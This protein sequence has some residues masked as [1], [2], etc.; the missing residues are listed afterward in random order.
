MKEIVLSIGSYDGLHLGHQSIIKR[1]K[2]ISLDKKISSAIFFFEIP[3]KLYLKGEFKNILITTPDERRNIIKGLGIDEIIPID[4]NE[5]IHLMEPDSFFKKFVF[6]KYKVSD[7]VVGKDFA[8]GYKR[9]GD[10]L[11]L[12]SYSNNIGFKLHIVDFVKYKD[13]KISSSLIRELIKK[14]EMEDVNNML[15]RKYSFHGIVKKGAGIGRKLGY[16]TANIDVDEKKLLPHGVFVVEVI[17][18]GVKY[19][20]VGSIGRRPTLKTLNEELIA[21]VHIL[22]FNQEIYGKKIEIFIIHK[23]RDEKKFNSVD[24]LISQIKEDVFYTQRYFTSCKKI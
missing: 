1:I 17:I 15:G 2:Q 4:F 8:L 14:G 21:E 22:D 5:D 6:S 12:K 10:L 20:G 24:A 3:P 13:H 23:I 9:K 18:D 11:W 19:N 7:M 16:P